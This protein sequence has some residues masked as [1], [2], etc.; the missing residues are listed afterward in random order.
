MSTPDGLTHLKL[1][2]L[3]GDNEPALEEHI[4]FC[5]QITRWGLPNLDT[6]HA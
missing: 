6:S 1:G 5:Y 3:L 4:D 2:T